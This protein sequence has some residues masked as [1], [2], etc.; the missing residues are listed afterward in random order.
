MEKSLNPNLLIEQ[1]G[2]R[3]GETRTDGKTMAFL[4][5]LFKYKFKRLSTKFSL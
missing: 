1:P 2:I 4:K 5:E 3:V